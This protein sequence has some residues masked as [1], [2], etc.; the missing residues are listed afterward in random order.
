MCCKTKELYDLTASQTSNVKFVSKELLGHA[1]TKINDA[2]E[3]TKFL[4]AG[5]GTK[6]K[7]CACEAQL[8]ASQ[9]LKRAQKAWI[10]SCDDVPDHE[11][12]NE[13]IK[14]GY[15]INHHTCCR[16]IKSLFTC[17]NE[18]VNVWTHLLGAIFFFFLFLLLCF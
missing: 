6:F 11:V 16:S 12:D 14:S 4:V 15:R 5:A 17:H 8:K 13:F 7:N 3:R 9:A 18:S 1:G 10:G 2:T